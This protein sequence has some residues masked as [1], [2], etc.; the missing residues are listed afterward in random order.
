MERKELQ[1]EILTVEGYDIKDKMANER[2]QWVQEQ[3][4]LFGKIPNDLEKFNARF[5][6]EPALTPE[7]EAAR[8]AAA[9]E[10]AADK[11]KKK[12]KKA[13]K[14]KGKKG[15][16]EDK[17]ETTAKIGPNELVRKFDVFYEDYNTKWANRDETE[18][19]EQKYDKMMARDEV[20]PDVQKA[21]TKEVDEMIK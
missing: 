9:E 1:K 3:K 21:L 4:A 18:N 15:D 13:K 11:K 19:Q 8:A 10:A 5:N 7:E 17:A 20:M 6:E 14:K 12:D 16:K 2:R